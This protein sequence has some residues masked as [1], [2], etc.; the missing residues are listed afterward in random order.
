MSCNKS[1]S[2]DALNGQLVSQT[3]SARA[4]EISWQL[5]QAPMQ[6]SLAFVPVR[7]STPRLSNLSQRQNGLAN[8]FWNLV[9]RFDESQQFSVNGCPERTV[10]DITLQR[11]CSACLMMILASRYAV[12]T[13]VD[14]GGGFNSPRLHLKAQEITGKTFF[15]LISRAFFVM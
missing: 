15:P 3:C 7:G 4:A 6:P 8:M 13:C 5:A 2:M 12:R 10:G 14:F 11:P 1:A 9:P